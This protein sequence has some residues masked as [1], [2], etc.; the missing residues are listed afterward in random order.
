M[1]QLMKK[2]TL[3]YNDLRK[4]RVRNREVHVNE[5]IRYELGKAEVTRNGNVSLELS[6]IVENYRNMEDILNW[7]N[8]KPTAI[9]IYEDVSISREFVKYY[10]QQQ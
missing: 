7:R 6:N 2:K 4:I 8:E 9:Q 5:N 3:C 10:H 1:I